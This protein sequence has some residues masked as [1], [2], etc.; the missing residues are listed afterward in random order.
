MTEAV[1]IACGAL[2]A[3]MVGPACAAEVDRATSHIDFSL[4]TRWGQALQ[5]RFPEFRGEVA[6]LADGRHQVRLQLETG[7]VEIIGHSTYTRATR[8]GG[9]FD[10]EHYPLV[11]FVSDA[12]DPELLR[13]GGPLPGVLTVHG[14]SRREI[15]TVTPAACAAPARD[16]D[17]FASGHIDRDDY[18]MGRWG[19]ALG[20][21]V[22]FALRMRVRADQP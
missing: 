22:D 1:R 16:C 9:F 5:G 6:A 18:A 20:D 17:V 7:S 2:L 10:A 11:Q 21:T 19:F 3:A 14:I 8:G 13:Q 4:K 15:F 12:Y